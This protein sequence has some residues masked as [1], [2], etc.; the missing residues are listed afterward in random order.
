[1]TQAL[2][3]RLH[4]QI[5]NNGIHTLLRF[6]CGAACQRVDC[7]GQWVCT[8][9]L[10]SA[11][12]DKRLTCTYCRSA[13]LCWSEP[14]LPAQFASLGGRTVCKHLHTLGAMLPLFHR[15]STHLQTAQLCFAA[16]IL[17]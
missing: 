8:P 10:L 16:S 2:L 6:A 14:M 1:M 17:W 7:A 5:S 9:P 3:P 13:L 15:G 4:L 11:I 12:V